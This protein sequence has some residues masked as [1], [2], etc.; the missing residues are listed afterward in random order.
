MRTD[1]VSKCLLSSS[2][3]SLLLPCLDRLDY[4]TQVVF[5][6]ARMTSCD[7]ML[8][9]SQRRDDNESFLSMSTRQ[10]PSSLDPRSGIVLALQAYV[11]D[12][13]GVVH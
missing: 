6:K 10:T 5:L 11:Q 4:V 1:Q 7:V 12:L 9:S 8:P 3:P 13:S 2:C